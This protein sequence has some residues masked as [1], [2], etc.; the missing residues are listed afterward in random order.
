MPNRALSLALIALLLGC[1]ERERLTFSPDGPGGDVEGPV[2]TIESPAIDTLFTEGDPLVV[3]GRVID[4]SGVDSVYFEVFG[5][6]QSYLPIPGEGQ[7]TVNFGLP[8]PTIGLSGVNVIV[9]I[10]GVDQAGNQGT[11]AVRQIL[12]E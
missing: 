1:D 9:R 5:A 6:G 7:D 8:I 2:A 10:H 12:I 4:P 3:G 11:A